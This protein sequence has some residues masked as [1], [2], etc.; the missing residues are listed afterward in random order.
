MPVGGRRRD[1][2]YS[3]TDRTQL[4]RDERAVPVGLAEHGDSPL[5]N[6]DD[7]CQYVRYHATPA[8]VVRI[9]PIVTSRL[10]AGW[11]ETDEQFEQR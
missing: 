8:A 10:E 6:V 5:A 1:S 4:P 3:E 7:E 2:G 9:R 11:A